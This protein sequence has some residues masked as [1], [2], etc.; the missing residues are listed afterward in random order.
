[1]TGIREVGGHDWAHLASMTTQ[2]TATSNPPLLQRLRNRVWITTAIKLAPLA[3]LDFLLF[4]ATQRLHVDR[5]VVA[6]H[7]HT[8]G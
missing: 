4:S 2:G 1:M 6:R 3:A 7:F 8:S 5:H